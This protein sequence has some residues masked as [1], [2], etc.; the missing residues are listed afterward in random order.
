M[1]LQ[2]NGT[3]NRKF[4]VLVVSPDGVE[5]EV[6]GADW[7]CVLGADPHVAACVSPAPYSM[8]SS[9]ASML[10]VGGV[11]T[12]VPLNVASLTVSPFAVGPVQRDPA[13][14]SGVVVVVVTRVVVV[15]EPDDV[16]VVGVVTVCAR[17][18]DDQIMLITAMATPVMHA[19]A[20]AHAACARVRPAGA[21]MPRVAPVS[22]RSPGRP[23]PRDASPRNPSD[24]RW[25]TS[26]WRWAADSPPRARRSAR[27]SR[28]SRSGG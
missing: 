25:S 3:S 22:G 7:S 11:C 17:D 10:G 28:R 4:I 14:S 27:R 19:L 2:T 13:H 21:V 15:L 16:G 26:G 18:G 24:D 6:V 23:A 1:P 5:V 9:T 20:T 12:N 8:L